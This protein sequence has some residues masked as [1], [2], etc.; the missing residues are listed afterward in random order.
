MT[1]TSQHTIRR[2]KNGSIDIAFYINK[3]HEIRSRAAHRSLHR[4]KKNA[5]SDCNSILR[6]IR[7]LAESL[8]FRTSRIKG[9]AQTS[10]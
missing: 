7:N 2:N 1:T 6:L 4:T 8:E 5:I 3:S 9:E 10:A